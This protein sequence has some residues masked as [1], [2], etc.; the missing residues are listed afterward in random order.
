MISNL[1]YMRIHID[2]HHYTERIFLVHVYV[3]F[4]QRALETSKHIFSPMDTH[5]RQQALDT[6]HHIEVNICIIMKYYFT[7]QYEMRIFW[8]LEIKIIYNIII[9]F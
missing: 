6:F 2:H 7:T 4:F 8:L 3:T 1:Y 9:I 5:I